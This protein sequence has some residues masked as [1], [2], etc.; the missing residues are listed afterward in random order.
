[1]K[2]LTL[3]LS[4]MVALSVAAPAHAADK[5]DTSEK[6]L[7]LLYAQNCARRVDSIQEKIGKLRAEIEK[8][9]RV[10]TKEELE[11]LERKL[12]E[13]EFLLD[14]IMYGPSRH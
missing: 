2:N 1:M 14:R 6:D 9:T 10:Y 4:M 7:C 8:G 5:P 13:A 12:K 3:L 11:R